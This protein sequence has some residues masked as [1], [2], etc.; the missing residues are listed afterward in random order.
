MLKLQE[1][2]FEEYIYVKSQNLGTSYLCDGY[3]LDV[4]FFPQNCYTGIDAEN[5]L[6]R[7]MPQYAINTFYHDRSYIIVC[8]LRDNC[9][10]CIS[11]NLYLTQLSNAHGAA[12]LAKARFAPYFQVEPLYAERHQDRPSLAV[13]QCLSCSAVQ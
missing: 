7:F 11:H 9:S 12:P 10:N 8:K 3:Y 2:H 6:V 13:Q 1:Q 4:D 5:G